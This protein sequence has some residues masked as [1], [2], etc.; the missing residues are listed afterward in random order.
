MLSSDSQTGSM[1]NPYSMSHPAPSRGRTAGAGIQKPTIS[2]W[3]AAFTNPRSMASARY[4]PPGY[5]MG[6]RGTMPRS[7]S[8]TGGRASSRGGSSG[9]RVSAPK[10]VGGGSPLRFGGGYMG[11]YLSAGSTGRGGGGM[12]PKGSSS[13]GRASVGMGRG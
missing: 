3:P 4:A 9:A 7:A 8:I 5:G 2:P 13:F 1:S 12:A 11:G 6:T 10:A